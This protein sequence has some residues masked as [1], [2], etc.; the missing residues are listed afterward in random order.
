MDRPAARTRSEEAERRGLADRHQR[1]ADRHRGAAGAAGGAALT[2]DWLEAAARCFEPKTLQWGSPAE[3]AAAL[4]PQR[5]RTPALDL[6]D[7]ELVAAAA[8]PSTR[9][10]VSLPPQEGKSELCS[11][12]GLLWLL[13]TN[14]DLRVAVASYELETASRWGRTIRADILTYDGQDGVDLGLRLRPD[15]TAAA[16]W[17][18]DGHR[19]GLY[20][21][22]VGGALTG[23]PVDYLLI[24]DP[25][26]GRA[27]A[28]SPVFRE[29]A[30]DWWQNVARTRLAPGAPV[31]LILTRWHEDDLA[32]R[33]IAQD[34]EDD[35]LGI[36]GP[37]WRV[38][39][40]PAQAGANDPLGRQPGEW[41]ISARG[42]T[43]AEWEAIRRDVGSRVWSALYQGGPTPP[44]GNLF[45]RASIDANRVPAAAVPEMRIVREYV[46]P[47]FSDAPDAD[48]TGRVVMGLGVDGNA[49]LLAD[50]SER[51]PFDRCPL[52]DS[53]ATHGTTSVRVEQNMLGKRVLTIISANLPP[54]VS[55]AGIP[56]KGTKSQRA[57]AVANLV[58]NG[59]VKFAGRFHE[60]E[61]QLLGWKQTD[62][63]S[64]DRLD[65][66]V[67][68]V[69][70][71]LVDSGL[72]PS[73]VLDED[74]VEAGHEPHGTWTHT[75]DTRLPDWS[76]DRDERAGSVARSPY[77]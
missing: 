66:F 71:L 43:A 56:A 4:D 5:V 58:D 46:D 76:L 8:T 50:L 27:E 7:R 11:H 16:R 33:L 64:P 51:R 19:G 61:A 9:L 55:V 21:V 23:R 49:Y 17:Q 13:A 44:E 28:D 57:E 40:I 60:L 67:H 74:P 2:L 69:R 37:R 18:L 75:P 70:E 25:I 68:G 73:F 63:D 77:A 34:A 15:S 59:R 24:D 54:H 41:L 62:R 65:A 22:G 45:H 36:P 30:W 1:A 39:N 3:L 26:K 38:V 29:R 12:Y 32:G 72:P 48:E 6:I 53:H 14:P 35:R 31:V 20:S 47:S 42:R 10:I 52:G